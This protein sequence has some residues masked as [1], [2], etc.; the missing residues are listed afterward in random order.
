MA[1]SPATWA[2]GS[3]SPSRGPTRCC[4]ATWSRWSALAAPSAAGLV[5]GDEVVSVDGQ[6][7]SGANSYLFNQMTNVMPGTVVTLGLARGASVQVTA[8]APP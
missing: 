8:G 1:I 2:S 5:P 3:S 4:F 6:A 7:V